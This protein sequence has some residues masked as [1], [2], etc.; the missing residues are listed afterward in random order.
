MA[1]RKG[2]AL[3]DG[4]NALVLPETTTPTAEGGIA[5]VYPKSDNALYFQDGAGVEKSLSTG[6]YPL[7]ATYI[8]GTGTAGTDNTAQTVK[9]VAIP[10]NELTQ[11]GDRI[12]VR[13]WWMGDTGAGI[14]ATVTVNG[15][16]IASSTDAG[17]ADLFATESWLH[18]V[19]ATH[20]NIIE[21]GTYPATGAASAL[22]VAGF[23]WTSAQDVDVDQD[24]VAG[25][26]IVVAA[27]FLDV[28]PKGAI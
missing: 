12:R 3:L 9:T 26:H 5:K 16:T 2:R 15:V 17:A 14:T 24:M 21:N 28:L 23:D 4:D 20:A 18:Y 19:D 22:N 25:N 13:T 11:V 10:A 27:I 7:A 8:S 6:V 1:V